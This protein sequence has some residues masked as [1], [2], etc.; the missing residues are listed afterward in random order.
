VPV[1]TVAIAEG[2][3]EVT[4]EGDA[5]PHLLPDGEA[6]S[7]VTAGL[8]WQVTLQRGSRPARARHFAVL[9]RHPYGGLATLRTEKARWKARGLKPKIMEV[10]SVFGVM[11]KVFDSRAFLLV[12]G[13]HRSRAAAIRL[14]EEQ[15]QK[16]GLSQPHAVAKLERRSAGSFVAV[17][18]DTSRAARAVVRV[19]DALWFAPPKSGKLTVS[20]NDPD[21]NGARVNKPYWGEVY[22]T[23][24][25][26]GKVAVVNA[27]PAD[28]LL[29]GLVPAEIFASAPEAALRTQAVAARGHLLAK[30]GTRHM[31]DPYLLCSRVHCQVYAGAG[32]EHPRA[33]AAVKATRG[34]LLVRADGG[35]VD[36]VYS[37]VCGGHTEHNDNVWPVPADGNLRGHLDD[38][39]GAA[40]MRPYRRGITE[41]NITAWLA[42]K[43]DSWCA[44]SRY[45]KNKVRWERKISATRMNRL[46][47]NLGVGAVRDLRVLSRGVS[48]RARAVEVVGSKGTATVKRE[49]TIRR[50]FGN[51]HSSMF[52]VRVRKT[53]GGN[54]AEF[55]FTGGGW[56]HGVG[57]CQTGATGMGAA[58]KSHAEILGHYY[59]GS[60]LKK[61]Y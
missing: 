14:S 54:P 37:A 8:R 19:K 2:L 31:A 52:T 49:L 16:H 58:G 56:G 55:I 7:R 20:Y 29:A 42:R 53:P 28:R 3:Q 11:G 5:A 33:T 35:L 27:V 25:R 9:A 4:I 12:N 39:R 50:R 18:L 24:D 48:G 47:A 45:N 22:V 41:G 26:N 34:E 60:Q 40:A 6:G 32:H 57:M 43:P 44:R 46:T 17:A 21:R 15:A 30:I 23:V 61:L 59:P 51:L 1:V 38:T 10:G 13:P 36:T